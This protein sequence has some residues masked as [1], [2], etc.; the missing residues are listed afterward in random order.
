MQQ[1]PA[2][3]ATMRAHLEPWV[4]ELITLVLAHWHGPLMLQVENSWH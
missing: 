3:V 4:P 1:L 2:L